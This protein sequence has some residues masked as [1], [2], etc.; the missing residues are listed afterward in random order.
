[1]TEPYFWLNPLRA[2]ETL[3]VLA[4]TD[5]RLATLLDADIRLRLMEGG[6]CRFVIPET[7]GVERLGQAAWR[8]AYDALRAAIEARGV[9]V[10]EFEAM[11]PL[12]D[13]H[14]IPIDR[15]LV[16]LLLSSNQEVGRRAA[17]IDGEKVLLLAGSDSGARVDAYDHLRYHATNLRVL[18]GRD[19]QGQDLMVCHLR[20]DPDRLE[21]LGGLLTSGKLQGAAVLEAFA[22]ANGLVCLPAN[23][24]PLVTA[25]EQFSDLFAQAY[26]QSDQQQRGEILAASTLPFVAIAVRP[27]PDPHA[28]ETVAVYLL[29]GLRPV[30]AD[31]LKPPV[32]VQVDLHP[33]ADSDEALE[34]L[35]QALAAADPPVGYQPELREGYAPEQ[36]DV[37]IERL[38]EGIRRMEDRLA[39]LDG[40]RAP[41]WRLLRFT[42]AQLPGL[43]DALRCFST[44]DLER[45][46][47]R[48]G[49]QATDRDPAGLHYLLFQPD[50]AVMTEPFPHWRWQ[51][52]DMQPMQFRLD[53]YWARY[54]HDRH[55]QSL[56][57]VP[58]GTALFP[59]LHS[60]HRTD[61]EDHLRSVVQSWLPQEDPDTAR[62]I[63]NRPVYVFTQGD[64]HSGR[65][66]IEILDFDS[67][68]PVFERI[69]WINSN[70]ELVDAVPAEDLIA[71]MAE[72][73]GRN[74]L[75]KRV[76]DESQVIKDGVPS[77]IDAARAATAA[78]LG[79]LL[80]ELGT[81]IDRTI[82]EMQQ[83]TEEIRG[84][85]RRLAALND[86]LVDVTAT[87][88][89]GFAR[90]D[91]ET[92]AARHYAEHRAR[93][94]ED[95]AARLHD[96]RNLVESVAERLKDQIE[97]LVEAREELQRRT[98]RR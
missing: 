96:A 29:R 65:L 15:A 13:R 80:G 52:I 2:A 67:L 39:Y 20:A 43:A 8:E 98:A 58:D 68:A 30:E 88:D 60:W 18:A 31:H 11:A 76:M 26:D 55:A 36:V 48:Y 84:K 85:H 94:E 14:D 53:P 7:T 66:V 97:A 64:R 74:A 86:A 54:Y 19:D 82:E 89:A 42:Q 44:P 78:E 71:A 45:G 70:I 10:E 93:V 75:V 34:R 62:I 23:R 9:V 59:P 73:A 57:F 61:M 91:A 21:T 27:A 95:M 17:P 51:A 81:E 33:L 41:V 24:A 87:T 50:N 38:G 37:E 6:W 28:A 69:D 35:R 77:A 16:W 83:V 12:D 56:L 92:N 22:S 40:L 3:T 46:V 47:I 49:F 63:P 32:N 72:E 4:G 1:M 90:F 5:V 79:A 25:L